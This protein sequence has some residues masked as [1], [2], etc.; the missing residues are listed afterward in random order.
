VASISTVMYP[1]ISKMAAEKQ[2][3][4]P[5]RLRFRSNLHDKPL[6]NPSDNRGDDLLEKRSLHSFLDGVHLPQRQLI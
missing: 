2:P 6:G 3:E 5:K 4:R 1:M